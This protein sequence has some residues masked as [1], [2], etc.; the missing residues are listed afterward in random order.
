MKS[1]LIFMMKLE[2]SFL[3]I[4][5]ITFIECVITSKFEWFH[6]F[7]I[8]NSYINLHGSVYRLYCFIDLVLYSYD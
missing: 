8:L 2:F 4:I 5:P 1:V 6:S 7:H 3:L